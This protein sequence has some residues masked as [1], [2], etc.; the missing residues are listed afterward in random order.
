M[1][2]SPFCLS[3]LF[4]LALSGCGKS[5][6]LVVPAVV[7]AA[8]PQGEL[9]SA[10]ACEPASVTFCEKAHKFCEFVGLDHPGSEVA[11][12]CAQLDATCRDSKTTT[13]DVCSSVEAACFADDAY[14]DAQCEG[15]AEKCR[16]L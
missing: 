7:V 5:E 4:S 13:C 9:P 11:D 12:V 3:V 10:C 6:P 15:L 8:A 16:C 14:D 2:A 1:R